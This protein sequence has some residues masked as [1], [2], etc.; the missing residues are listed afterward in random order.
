MAETKALGVFAEQPERD[1]LAALLEQRASFYGFLS[2]LYEKEVDKDFLDQMCA[3]KMRRSTGNEDVDS[4]NEL[5]HAFLSD[6]W[7][8][9]E[10]DLRI[11]YARVFFGNGMSGVSAAYPFE[12]VHTSSEHLLMQDA[13]DKVL[14]LYRAE[15]F[16]KS[17]DWKDNE[18]HVAL[19]LAFEGIL[20]R[21]AADALAAGDDALCLA[22]LVAQYNFLNDHLLNWIS[23]LTG[24]IE[25]F[26]QTDFYRA[27]ARLTMGFLREDKPFLED[28][29]AECDAT[30]SC[31][32]FTGEC[33]ARVGRCEAAACGE[34]GSFGEGESCD[35]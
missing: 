34:G 6:R 4:A 32:P 15:G 10:E 26:T 14:A 2:R 33:S 5:L 11:D 23:L 18:D 17:E 16:Q 29:L 8:R 19:E 7:E 25:R 30:V 20:C 31:D 22:K 24:G 13:R 12:S 9:T 21:K 35:E 3:M 27:V 28:V 1:M